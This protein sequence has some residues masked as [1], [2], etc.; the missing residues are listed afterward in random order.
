MNLS[1]PNYTL[2]EYLKKQ[3]KKQTNKQH[4]NY[5]VIFTT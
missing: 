5:P 2:I 3:K 4:K 1:S